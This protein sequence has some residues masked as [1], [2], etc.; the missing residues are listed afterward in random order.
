MSV[1]RFIFSLQSSGHPLSNLDA[2]VILAVVA[3]AGRTHEEG[4][5]NFPFGCEQARLFK[6]RI[7]MRKAFL[8]ALTP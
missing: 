5:Y 4:I 8:D 2:L 7:E 6:G 1:R 3:S